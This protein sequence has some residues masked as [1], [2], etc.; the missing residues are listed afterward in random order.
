MDPRKVVELLEQQYGACEWH[1]REAPLDVLVRTLLSQNTSDVNSRR[2]FH[3]LKA[4]FS[5]W[6]DVASASQEDI[7]DAIRPGGLFRVK[8]ARIKKILEQIKKEQNGLDL[9]FLGSRNADEAK[10]YLL[11]L[12]GVG[13]K[14]ASCVLLFSFKKP[15][16]PVDTHILRVAKRLGLIDST[17]SV[18]KAHEVLQAKIP[19]EKVYQFHIH[20]IE[21]GRRICRPRQPRC[22]KCILNAICRASGGGK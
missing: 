9:D 21:H 7:A 6:E 16:L 20:M 3:A 2:A 1:Q 11:R 19:P 14:T 4:R 10:A 13:L 5:K 15:C 17:V 22:H 8:A 18:E 12:P